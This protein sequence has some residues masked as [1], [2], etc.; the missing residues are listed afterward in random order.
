M[1]LLLGQKHWQPFLAGAL[2]E[3]IGTSVG[4]AYARQISKIVKLQGQT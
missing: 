2:S 1:K 4:V 3:I